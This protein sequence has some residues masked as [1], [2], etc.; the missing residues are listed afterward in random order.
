MAHRR[1]SPWPAY[2]DLFGAL[3]VIFIVGW[4][5]A[6]GRYEALQEENAQFRRSQRLMTRAQSQAEDLLTEFS[7]TKDF[8]AV[9]VH[10]CSADVRDAVCF[11]V[12][13]EFD[14]DSDNIS[15]ETDRRRL[16]ALARDLKA[17][18][19]RPDPE[20]R[21]SRRTLQ[22]VIEGH[23]DSTQPKNAAAGR[24]RFKYNWDLSARRAS[25]VMY[26]LHQAGLRKEEYNLIAWGRADTEPRCLEETPEC[27]ERNRR[28]TIKVRFDYTRRRPTGE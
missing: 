2:V 16:A 23:T 15:R 7:K 14:L 24:A 12:Q 9:A 1:F 11:D 5:S 17:W 25:A 8:G 4:M 26:E 6:S 20:S 27:L 22:V 28:T 21:E 3:V 19:D 13:L 18:F 10:P